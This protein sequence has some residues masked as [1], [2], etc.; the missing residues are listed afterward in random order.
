MTVNG[1]QIQRLIAE[2]IA[3]V[4][5]R[6]GADGRRGGVIAVLSGATVGF[7]EAIRQVRLLSLGGYRVGLA[8]SRAAQDLYGETFVS[9]LAGFP[10]L[11]KVDGG[12]WLASL[13]AARAVVVPLLS[14]NTLSKVALLTPDNL[15]ANLIVH[16]LFMGKPVIVAQ[17]GANPSDPGREKLGFD[18]GDAAL[19]RALWER[20]KTLQDYGCM[21]V[22]IGQLKDAVDSVLDGSP[23]TALQGDVPGRGPLRQAF[24]PA[25]KVITAAEVTHARRSGA[26]LYIAGDALLTPL[27]RELAAR[28]GVV[29]RR[30]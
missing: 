12:K 8:F 28:L 9:Q 10:H 11:E 30:Q 24:S 6:L 20:L 14:V 21:L 23:A 22:D 27:A 16:A 5:A 7:G 2:V 26:D 29:L 1:E 13:Q 25:P 18:Q 3:R 19:G 15:A 17:N 4:A